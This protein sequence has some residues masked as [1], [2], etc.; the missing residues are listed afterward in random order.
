MEQKL[1]LKYRSYSDLA[2]ADSKVQT[3]I[4]EARKAAKKSHAPYSKFNVG[5]AARLKS[6]T[7]LHGAN[8]ESEVYPA[9]VCAERNLLFN[10]ATNHAEDPIESLAIVSLS[11]DQECYPCGFCRQ[12]LV[13]AERRQGAK[14]EVIMAGAKT[15]KVVDT[16]Q[17][18]VPFTFE[19]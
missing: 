5:A 19:L 18:L 1:E 13:D 8:C 15:A 6:G 14:I 10:A 17:T 4:E 3:L 11:T 2:Q 12:S 9:G 7:I 16:A